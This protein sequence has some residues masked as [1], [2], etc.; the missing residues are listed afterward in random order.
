MSAHRRRNNLWMSISIALCI[1][2]L[3]WIEYSVTAERDGE[4]T[5]VPPTPTSTPLPS[6]T[7]EPTPVL[8]ALT[9]TPMPYV[10]VHVRDQDGNP[11]RTRRVGRVSWD[12]D[13]NHVYGG[14][15]DC[16]EF[17]SPI[18]GFC[19]YFGGMVSLYEGQS[20]VKAAS[21]PGNAIATE[22]DAQYRYYGYG[23]PP[24]SEGSIASPRRI[25]VT[26][27]NEPTLFVQ[28][29]HL[30]WMG[31]DLLTDDVHPVQGLHGHATSRSKL[32]IE[33]E[34]PPDDEG[35]DCGVSRVYTVTSNTAGDF[36]LGAA[37]ADDPL[38]G[39]TCQ[40]EWRAEATDLSTGLSGSVTWSVP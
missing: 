4:I 22:W 27:A 33:V 28:Q 36:H 40:G 7:P 31:A 2:A 13:G 1:L 16:S 6:T 15:R 10:A 29:S 23:W 5:E 20:I 37:D 18:Y 24:W 14:C 19:D 39:A 34:S 8:T 26:V 12:K 38:F 35:T 30:V 25:T 9:L 11:V 32:K 17:H 3:L 21:M